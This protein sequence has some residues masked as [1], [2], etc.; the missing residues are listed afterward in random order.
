LTPPSDILTI[1]P[2]EH[3]L[4]EEPQGRHSYLHRDRRELPFLQ[5]V[6]LK[7]LH[8]RGSQSVWWLTEIICELFDR[9]KIATDC[10]WGVVAALEF[11]HHP[12][13]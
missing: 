1:A 4:E 10:G 8:V 11:L 5:Q 7:P 12:L 3:L 9:E 2:F 13:F 6:P